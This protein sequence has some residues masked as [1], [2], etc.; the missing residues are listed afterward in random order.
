MS[1]HIWFETE[2]KNRFFGPQAHQ[3]LSMRSGAWDPYGV[4]QPNYFA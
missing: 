3:P 2:L 1:G 4:R